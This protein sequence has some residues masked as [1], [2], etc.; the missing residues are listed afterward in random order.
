MELFLVKDKV[1]SWR[2]SLAPFSAI[3]SI[4]FKKTKFVGKQS[5]TFFVVTVSANK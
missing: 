1:T 3:V 4:F 2:N 5:K